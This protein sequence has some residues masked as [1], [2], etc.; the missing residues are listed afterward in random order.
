MSAQVQHR[1]LILETTLVAPSVCHTLPLLI[2]NTI[3]KL[4][5]PLEITLCVRYSNYMYK[6]HILAMLSAA[7]AWFSNTVHR[8]YL[9]ACLSSETNEIQ[10][11]TNSF[12]PSIRLNVRPSKDNNKKISQVQL[13]LTL[14]VS[15]II[16]TK[17]LRPLVVAAHCLLYC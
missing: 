15:H 13:S 8:S 6:T 3:P 12:S 11:Y 10:T 14:P 17:L 1:S 4:E 16:W 9:F 5:A 2:W 7:S